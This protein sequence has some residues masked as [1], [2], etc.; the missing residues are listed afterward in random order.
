MIGDSILV[1]VYNMSTGLEVSL[2]RAKQS[3]QLL[4]HVVPS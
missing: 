1:Q 2:D 3:G 4:H